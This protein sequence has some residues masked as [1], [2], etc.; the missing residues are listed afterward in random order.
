VRFLN[1]IFSVFLVSIIRSG[2]ADEFSPPVYI[3]LTIDDGPLGGMSEILEAVD[4]ESVEVTLLLVGSHLYGKDRRQTVERGGE[5]PL[6]LIGN[7][8]FSHANNHYIR[9]YQ[10]PQNVLKDFNKNQK[11]LG[12]SSKIARLPGRNM[13]EVGSRS[14]YDIPSGKTSSQLL[15]ENGYTVFGWDIEWS[16]HS[17]TTD[18]NESVTRLVQQIDGEVKKSFTPGHVVIL[19]HDQMFRTAPDGAELRLLIRTLKNKGYIFRTLEHYPS[20]G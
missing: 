12:I 18:S 19:A 15:K 16:H 20:Q 9:Y 5:N 11:I 13:W 3:Y 4:S 14:Q 17:K 6:V 8:S 7:H 1:L 2:V 10:D